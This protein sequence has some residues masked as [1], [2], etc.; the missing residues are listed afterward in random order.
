MRTFTSQMAVLI[1]QLALGVCAAT[2][3]PMHLTLADFESASM[4]DGAL[5]KIDRNTYKVVNSSYLK[6]LQIEHKGQW[7][8]Q[9]LHLELSGGK[10][11][12]E[13]TYDQGKRNGPYR[14]YTIYNGQD[15]IETMGNYADGKKSGDWKRYDKGILLQEMSYLNDVLQGLFTEYR[16]SGKLKGE[17]A[18]TR[19]YDRG[20]LQGETLIYSSNNGKLVQRI[21]YHQNAVMKHLWYDENSGMVLRESSFESDAGF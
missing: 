5:L 12:S 10:L 4:K 9:G 18:Y 6:G 3:D 21:L 7:V 20:K 17:I 15:V 16:T 2:P 19:N 11:I 1:L 14:K 13:I 8:S